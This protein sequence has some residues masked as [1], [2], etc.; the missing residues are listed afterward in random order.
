[1]RKR[2][3][4]GTYITV[5]GHPESRVAGDLLEELIRAAVADGH[6]F[7]DIVICTGRPDAPVT[8]HT[9]RGVILVELLPEVGQHLMVIDS[10]VEDWQTHA[11]ELA[12]KADKVKKARR[13]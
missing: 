5:K 3:R 8:L 12:K 13:K 10:S 4:P 9:G 11:I 1:M 6:A 7:D 2:R